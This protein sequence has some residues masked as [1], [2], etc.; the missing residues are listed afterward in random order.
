MYRPWGKFD[1]R[2]G[3]HPLAD[4]CLDVAQVC[5]AL[6]DMPNLARSLSSLSSACKDRLAVIAFLHDFGKCNR[7]FQA[8]ADPSAKPR[9]AAG[10]V[11]E[12]LGFLAS[13]A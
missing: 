2:N 5:R 11:M 9:D 6:L 10:H 8:K 12:A 13:D 1:P 3:F 4:H 7:G